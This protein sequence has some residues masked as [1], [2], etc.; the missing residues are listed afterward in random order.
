MTEISPMDKSSHQDFGRLFIKQAKKYGAS[1]AGIADVRTTRQSPSHVFYGGLKPLKFVGIRVER[2]M[3]PGQ[4]AW[5]ETARSIAV[6]ALE[7]PEDQPELDWWRPDMTGGTPGNRSLMQINARLARWLRKEKGATVTSLPYNI[8]KGGIFL[9]DAAVMA[10]LGCIGR[11]NL[12]ITPDFGPRVRLRAMLLDVALPPTGPVKFDPCHKCDTPCRP[13]CP[14]KAF[15]NKVYHK[16]PS[17][18]AQLP[19]RTGVYARSQC[20]TQM[21][22]DIYNSDNIRRVAHSYGGK[23]VKYCRRC[24]FSCPVGR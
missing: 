12:L 18:L 4:A 7:H 8:D 14:Q 5:S 11:N 20:N 16:K 24:E 2:T 3:M 1:M 17:G 22:L 23:Q 21:E 9:K 6:I 10:G 13:I 15:K 19:G